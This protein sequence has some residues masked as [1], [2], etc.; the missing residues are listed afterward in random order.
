[1]RLLYRS[2]IQSNKPV[3][4]IGLALRYISFLHNGG[5]DYNGK[6]YRE[7]IVLIIKHF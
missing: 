4:I 1:M 2:S 3:G 7:T 6:I 5:G